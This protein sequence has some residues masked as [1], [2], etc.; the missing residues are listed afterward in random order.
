[1][2]VKRNAPF[3]A[4][5]IDDDVVCLQIVMVKRVRRAP[6][7][8]SARTDVGSLSF[9]NQNA[10]LSFEYGAIVRN[11]SLASCFILLSHHRP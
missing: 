4:S 9:S 6:R 11:G 1:M 5:D 2:N 7:M 8:V 3:S 10:T